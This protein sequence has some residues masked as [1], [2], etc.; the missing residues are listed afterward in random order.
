MVPDSF[1][2]FRSQTPSSRLIGLLLPG[3]EAAEEIG[4]AFLLDGGAKLDVAAGAEL[5]VL[6][7]L[8]RALAAARGVDRVDDL[9]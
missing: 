7:Q 6:K 2:Y 4:L 8:H 3:V 1:R 5:A 9:V